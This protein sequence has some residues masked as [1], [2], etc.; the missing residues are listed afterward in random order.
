MRGD[1]HLFIDWLLALPEELE[2]E[3]IEEMKKFE[4]G[5]EMAYV[6]SA[7]RLGREKGKLE[8]KV[9]GKLEGKLETAANMLREG[10]ELETVKRL[11]GLTDEQLSK[12]N[13]KG[14]K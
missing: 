12:I 9:E 5:K 13:E 3:Y 8:G 14:R 7:E 10:F 1:L 4:E 6:S 11:T 2:K